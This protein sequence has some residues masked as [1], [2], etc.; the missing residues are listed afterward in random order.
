[1]PIEGGHDRCYALTSIDLWRQRHGLAAAL[2]ARLVL[3]PFCRMDRVDGLIGWGWRKSGKRAARLSERYGKPLVTCE[4]G[5]LRSIGPGLKE[6]SRSFVIDRTGIHF[7]RMA[8]SDLFATI[9]RNDFT[10]DE[11]DLADRCIAEIRRLRLSKY[12]RGGPLDGDFAARLDARPMVLLVEQ[13][14]GDASI[15]RGMDV[16]AVWERMLADA[17]AEHP[18]AVIVVRPH[19][20]N[21]TR[22]RFGHES[23]T[24]ETL[25]C[26]PCNPWDLLERA[27]HV[28]TVASH[29]GFEALMAGKPV[30]TYGAPFYAGWQATTD[31]YEGLPSGQARSVRELFAAAYLR[32]SVYYDPRTRQRT[33]LPATIEALRIER[34]AFFEKSAAAPGKRT[35]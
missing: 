1:M 12:N 14:P 13:V 26:P 27:E 7:D 10:A 24:I 9:E 3:W 34:D 16:D 8:P 6:P 2:G 32:Y 20:A 22:R 23:A 21:R 35:G 31:R 15:P 5:F 18:D 19:P 30:T 11:L 29:L 25:E 17:R 4:D 33:T 28:Y